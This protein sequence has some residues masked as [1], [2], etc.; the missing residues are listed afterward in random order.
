ML[1]FIFI[2]FAHEPGDEPELWRHTFG[3]CA[4]VMH[5]EQTSGTPGYILRR[6]W[7]AHSGDEVR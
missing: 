1:E 3:P 6:E 7:N 4:A 2:R 5:G